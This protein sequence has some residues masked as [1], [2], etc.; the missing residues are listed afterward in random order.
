MDN[1]CKLFQSPHNF[2]SYA[3]NF[4]IAIGL[5]HSFCTLYITYSWI[6]N[7]ISLWSHG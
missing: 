5:L 2:I 4:V 7:R 1:L 3:P 6:A